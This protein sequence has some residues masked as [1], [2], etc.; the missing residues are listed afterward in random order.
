MVVGEFLVK[1]G[2]FAPVRVAVRPQEES[3]YPLIR[4]IRT[5]PRM[6]ALRDQRGAVLAP[7]NTAPPAS[8][9]SAK[10]W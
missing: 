5:D 7:L 10:Q 2:A 9:G 6:P 8:K 4:T 3:K 1:A